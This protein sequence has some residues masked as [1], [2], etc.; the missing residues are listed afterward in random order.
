MVLTAGAQSGNQWDP[1]D[2]KDCTFVELKAVVLGLW[3]H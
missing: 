3:I 2:E 1:T